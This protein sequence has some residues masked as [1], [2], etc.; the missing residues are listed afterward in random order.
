MNSELTLSLLLG[1]GLSAAC[2]LRVF[3]PIL[4][5]SIG[6]G[7]GY[8]SPSAGFLW[9]G[10]SAALAI[11]AAASVFE[12]FAYAVPRME[13]FLDL[14]STPAAMVAGTLL[15]AAALPNVHPLIGISVPLFVGGSVAGI[16]QSLISL[17]RLSAPADRQRQLILAEAAASLFFS[18]LA[19]LLPA[20]AG[21]LVLAY[22]AV[23]WRTVRE[24]FA[25]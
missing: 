5:L 10:S 1:V 13:R 9:I 8:V 21:L 3:L 14:V 6:A 22:L 24:A 17:L 23:R 11:I 12:L 18:A 16:S 7:T 15:T 19:I 20:P 25:R 2:G 4:A